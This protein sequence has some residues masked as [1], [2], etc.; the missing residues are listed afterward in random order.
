QSGAIAKSSMIVLK[1][2][3]PIDWQSLDGKK[4]DTVI[5][6]LIPETDSNAHLQYLSNTA[7]L[8]THE[9]F[10]ASLKKANTPEEIQALFENN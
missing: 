1:L 4:I 9:D 7:K 6:F 10:I 3:E 5:S 8:L 2:K